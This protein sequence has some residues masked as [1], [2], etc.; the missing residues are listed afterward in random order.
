MANPLNV[1]VVSYNSARLWKFTVGAT[2]MRRG[3]LCKFSSGLLVPLADN[4]ENLI[5]WVTLNEAA[6]N[7]TEVQAVPL[8]DCI[9]ALLYTGTVPTA[10]TALGV[11]YG[12]TGPITVDFDNTTQILVYPVKV[13][14][15]LGI[16]YVTG[17][18]LSV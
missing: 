7:A 9:V 16:V 2:A 3:S 1:R 5:V 8:T 10:P 14:T 18:N 6:A 15:N 17:Q 4:D 11:A 13:D 12:V